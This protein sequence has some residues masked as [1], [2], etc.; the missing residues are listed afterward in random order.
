MGTKSNCT[1]NRFTERKALG[2]SRKIK[3]APT[4][5]EKGTAELKG[6]LR[7]WTTQYYSNE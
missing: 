5:P 6:D 1:C 3:L 4:Q 7:Q 2:Q